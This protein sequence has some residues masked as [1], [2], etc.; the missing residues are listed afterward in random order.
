MWYCRTVEAYKP[1]RSNGDSL[2]HSP[3]MTDDLVAF[4]GEMD[5]CWMERRFS[6]LSAYLAEDVITVAPGGKQRLEGRDASI[7]SY[8]EFMS[9]AEVTSFH[10]HGHVVTQRGATAVVEYDWDIGWNDQGT[11]HE[12]S[13]RELLVLTRYDREWRVVWRTQLSV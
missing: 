5:R 7:E 13:G 4:T 11:A 2:C 1:G 8:R 12:A 10:S 6:D 9:R 3:A